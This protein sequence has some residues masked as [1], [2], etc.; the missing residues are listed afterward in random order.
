VTKTRSA[1]PAK[2]TNAIQVKSAAP[3]AVRHGASRGRSSRLWNAWSPVNRRSKAGN[4][5]NTPKTM[6]GKSAPPQNGFG[7]SV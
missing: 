2:K 7:K 5:N 4:A 1:D 6:S 3:I